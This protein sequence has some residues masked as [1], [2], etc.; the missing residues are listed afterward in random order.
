[1]LVMVPAD[2]MY[3]HVDQCESE[4]SHVEKRS[5]RS[6]QGEQWR[7]AAII[8]SRGSGAEASGSSTAGLF[9]GG[10]VVMA[11]VL[12]SFAAGFGM[13]FPTSGPCRDYKSYPIAL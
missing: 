2:Q 4:V 13:E 5:C 9:P 10:V 1:M 6:L 11:N 12:D 8:C 3:L 7:T